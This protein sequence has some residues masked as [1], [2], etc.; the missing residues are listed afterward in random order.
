MSAA[1]LAYIRDEVSEP[2]LADAIDTFFSS[3]EF[4]DDSETDVL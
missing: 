3:P 2:N 4:S 1:D